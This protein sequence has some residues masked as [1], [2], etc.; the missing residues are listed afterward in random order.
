MRI[1]QNVVASMRKSR[2][3]GKRWTQLEGVRENWTMKTALVEPMDIVYETESNCQTSYLSDGRYIKINAREFKV[4]DESGDTIRTV[5][6]SSYGDDVKIGEISGHLFFAVISKNGKFT[7]GILIDIDTGEV[8]TDYFK[9]NVTRVIKGPRSCRDGIFYS[10]I[11]N[12]LFRYNLMGKE[13][14][15]GNIRRNSNDKI[16]DIKFDG[17]DSIILVE[18][19]LDTLVVRLFNITHPTE[20]RILFEVEIEGNMGFHVHMVTPSLF[21]VSS[22]KDR[23]VAYDFVKGE[24][25][26]MI[27][28]FNTDICPSPDG[29]Y[30]INSTQTEHPLDHF[31]FD[32]ISHDGSRLYEDITTATRHYGIEFKLKQP[33]LYPVYTHIYGDHRWIRLMSDLTLETHD[34]HPGTFLAIKSLP[35]AI[36]KAKERAPGDELA[37]PILAWAYNLTLKTPFTTIEKAK[38]GYFK[39]LVALLAKEMGINS[40]K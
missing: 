28:T 13:L 1:I 37:L 20:S 17:Q 22:T 5:D 34:T 7:G 16:Q 24:V 27:Y 29:R 25:M 35:Y 6:I 3:S 4:F 38:R 19:A 36:V 21:C 32:E 33:L 11:N 9:T 31:M 39:S 8:Y 40:T 23:V 15:S 12:E 10:I 26:D 2:N 14:I 30:S 18:R